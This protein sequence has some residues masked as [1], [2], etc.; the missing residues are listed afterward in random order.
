MVRLHYGGQMIYKNNCKFCNSIFETKKYSKKFCTKI[1]I[2]NYRTYLKEGG[3]P[4]SDKEIKLTP[5]EVCG[6]IPEK[7]YASGRFCSFICNKK[8]SSNNSKEIRIE[9]TKKYFSDVKILLNTC[10]K[11]FFCKICNVEI[12]GKTGRKYCSKDCIKK[13]YT[14]EFKPKFFEN[15]KIIT[16]SFK[17]RNFGKQ[18]KHESNFG[19]IHCDSLLEWTC[20]EYFIKNYNL[21]SIERCKVRIPYEFKGCK[22]IYNPDFE[23]ITDTKKYIIEVKDDLR[24]KEGDSEKWNTYL[25]QAFEKKKVL[26]KW[27]SENGCEMFWFTPSIERRIYAEAKKKFSVKSEVIE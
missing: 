26:E 10:E 6:N 14:P 22:K 17:K 13:S 7:L 5:C 24:R 3:A 12:D 19:I 21:I 18:V 11:K 1:C 20:L 2:S 27:C 25:N 23:I 8:F 16:D 15:V 9:K 4:I